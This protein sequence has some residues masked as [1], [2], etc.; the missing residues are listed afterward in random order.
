MTELSSRVGVLTDGDLSDE[1][2]AVVDWLA[3]HDGVAVEPVPFDLLAETDAAPTATAAV[4][5]ASDVAPDAAS[6]ATSLGGSYPGPG[7]G[8]SAD[9]LHRFDVLWWHRAAPCPDTDPLGEAAPAIEAFLADGGG[10]FLTLHALA[11]VDSLSIES[12]APDRVDEEALVE[13]T[14]VLWRSLYAD[15]PA[16]ESLDGLRHPLRAHGVAP[17]VRY[18][19]VL[20]ANGE[21]LASTVRGDTEVPGQMTAVSWTAGDGAVLGLGAPVLFAD[22]PAP[23]GPDA[24]ALAE[25]RDRLVAGCL[26]SLTVRD[27][28]PGR[29]TTGDDLRR[30]R[31]RTAESGESGVGGRPKYH[32]TPPAN[33]LNDPNGLIRWNGRYHVFYQ[34]NPA[35]PFHNTIHWGHAVSDDLVTWRDEPVA[36]TPSPDGPDRDGCWSGCAVDDD[37]TASLLYTGGDGRDQLPCL[38]TTDDPGLRTWDKYDGN[39][40][41]ASPPADLDV[42]E[43]DHWRAE[44]RD[45]NVWRENGRWYHLVGTGLEDGG[46]AALLY[47]SETLTEWTYEGLLLAGGP[48][49]GAVWECPEL[50][51]LGD[52][53]LLHVSDY[54]NVVYFLG[55]FVDDEFTVESRGLLDHGD[56]YAPQSL[57]DG[58]RTLTWGWLPEARDVEGQWNA[59]WSGAMSLPRV[60]EAGPDGGLRQRPA[61]EVT[62]LRTERIAAATDV[63]LAPGDRRRLDVE[64]AAIELEIEIALDDAEAVEL[65][66]FETP[67]RAEHTPIRY[68]KDGTLS[69]DRAP[70]SGDPHAFADTQ[71]MSVPPYD[72]PLS[73]RIFLDRSVIEIYANERHCLTSRVYP[74]RDDAVGVSAVAEGGRAALTSLSAWTLGEAMPTDDS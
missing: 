52:R 50:L 39:P 58:D 6:D 37:G 14:G 18:E 25:T 28:T 60:I 40:V 53:R 30:L 67:D 7:V 62:E 32:L 29:P 9:T 41:I 21:V 56:F 55:S 43:T 17:A 20:P 49:A 69:V 5:P 35:G 34:Y 16:L 12:I 36:L 31:D 45:H 27:G 46:G 74:T 57:D 54:E 24:A 72:E 47:T 8:D 44:F 73:L 15:H 64:G 10:L 66:V 38:A 22:R 70:S 65:S 2:R 61:A 63:A 11:S 59:G 26:R 23:E 68:E 71:S 48:D 42:L 3:A 51:D 13:P 1:Q 33:W 19:R 4:D